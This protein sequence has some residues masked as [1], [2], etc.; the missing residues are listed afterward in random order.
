MIRSVYSASF[1]RGSQAVLLLSMAI[2]L[3]LSGCAT[4]SSPE[5][6]QPPTFPDGYVQDVAPFEVRGQ[7]GEPYEHPFLGGFT[8]PRPQFVDINNN[9]YPDLFV[10]ENNNQLIYF[11]N[12]P[13]E[14]GDY[15]LEWRTNRFED[16]NVGE[17]FR[18]VEASEG[19]RY[20]LLSEAPYS[21]IRYHRN[22]GTPE[23]PAFAVAADTLRD[24][25]GE[26]IFA[27]R[28]NI[29]NFADIDCDETPD[30]FLG[31]MEGTVTRY[32][33]TGYDEAGVPRFEHV[34]DRFQDIEIITQFGTLRHGANSFLF[35]DMTG[36]G[37]PDLLWG[38]F[39]ESSLLLIE[40]R[41]TCRNPNLRG[42][43]ENFPPDDPVNSS[44]YNAPAVVDWTRNG[45]LDL[46]V[47]VLGGAHDPNQTL[48]DNFY[49][50]SVDESGRY[51]LETERFLRM[52][53]VGSE[54]V[55]AFDDL[56]GNGAPD[57]LIG[58][59]IA[60]DDRQT[61]R[62][63]F[64]ENT[65]TPSEPAF[66]H[67]GPIDLPE[68]TYHLAPALGDLTGNGRPDLALGSWDGT[69]KIYENTGE[70]EAP[71]FADEPL[72]EIEIP[73]GRN[74]VPTLVDLDDD[75]QLDVVSGASDG[76][77]YYYRNTG[78]EDELAFERDEEVFD[79]IE[80]SR[81]SAPAFADVDDSGA[82]DLLLG[83]EGTGL[84]LHRNL[85]S[86]AAPV[87]GPAEPLDLDV[88]RYTTPTFVDLYDSGT[89]ALVTGGRSGGLMYFSPKR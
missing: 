28:Q 70:G 42:E 20:D 21:Y 9:G 66:E 25:E 65:G 82:P 69:V 8:N 10:Q 5:E 67:R 31:R 32:A 16:L 81:R 3:T 4:L 29:P 45:E 53:D 13:A 2:L 52:I 87:F 50:Y 59:K 62:L 23:E 47:G 84:I 85:G 26:A 77:L 74:A 30:L 17:W 58:N 40:N 24:V 11:E 46:F 34:T 36:D 86:R 49:F 51:R 35:E 19:D 68:S 72:Y 60:P 41:G 38:D 71:F 22:T 27:D 61:S 1:V 55:A 43:P 63:H 56:T 64:F 48:I 79:G 6:D 37:T 57:L 83:A 15:R 76:E 88:P 39:F 73:R 7:D 75:G 18:F 44:G 78:S 12:V 14:D 54:S 33:S 80:V 89:P